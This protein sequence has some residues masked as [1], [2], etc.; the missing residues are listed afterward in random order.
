MLERVGTRQKGKLA[1]LHKATM[2]GE[3]VMCKLIHIERVNNFV[4]ESFLEHIC[5]LKYVPVK[6]N[7]LPVVG[8]YFD[9]TRVYVF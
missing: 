1:G 3:D 6:Q 4:I 7:L 9:D 8:F 5:R 2:K